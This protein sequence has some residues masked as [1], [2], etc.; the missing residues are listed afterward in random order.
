[1]IDK[2]F[3]TIPAH[4]FYDILSEA[5]NVAGIFGDPSPTAQDDMH[6]LLNKPFNSPHSSPFTFAPFCHAEFV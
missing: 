5:K 4:F 6:F 3:K 1:M 2:I